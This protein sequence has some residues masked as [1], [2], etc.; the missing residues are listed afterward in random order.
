MTHAIL[1]SAFYRCKYKVTENFM[2]FL[3]LLVNISDESGVT[4]AFLNKYH[5]VQGL[6]VYITT[7][8]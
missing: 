8:R 7:Q 4:D 3:M 5:N 1:R 2:K 6:V